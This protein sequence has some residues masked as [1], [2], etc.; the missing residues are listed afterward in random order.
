MSTEKKAP[1]KPIKKTAMPAATPK[2]TF[3]KTASKKDRPEP[4]FCKGIIIFP[5]H[6]NAPDFV[7]GKISISLNDF[8]GFCEEHPELLVEHEKYG[9]Q[10]RF[11]LKESKEGVLYMQ[12]DTYGTE[13]AET[14]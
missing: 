2:K 5:P 4:V 12:V 11:E 8:T 7:K 9:P 6:E 10:I 14:E 3:G 1:Y 13:A